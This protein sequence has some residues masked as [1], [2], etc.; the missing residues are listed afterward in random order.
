MDAIY[1]RG[2]QNLHVKY[3][4]MDDIYLYEQYLQPRLWSVI[5]FIFTEVIYIDCDLSTSWPFLHFVIYL[6]HFINN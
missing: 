3:D 1:L 2:V 6:A 5:M 4:R